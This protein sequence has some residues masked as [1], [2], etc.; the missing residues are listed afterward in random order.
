MHALSRYLL[1]QRI[2]ASTSIVLAAWYLATYT[3]DNRPQKATLN[4]IKQKSRQFPAQFRVAD[5]PK[6]VCIQMIPI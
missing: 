1:L 3:N 4:A 2:C 6:R 5:T